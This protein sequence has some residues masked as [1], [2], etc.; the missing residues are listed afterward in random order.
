MSNNLISTSNADFQYP[1]DLNAES[2]LI[3]SCILD[4]SVLADVVKIIGP[5]NFYHT[6]HAIMFGEIAGLHK[7]GKTF[8][9]VILKDR[10][11]SA[12]T[13]DKVGGPENIADILQSVPTS[14][15]AVYYAEIIFE[16]YLL[17]TAINAAAHIMAA[18]SQGKSIDVVRGLYSDAVESLNGHDETENQRKLKTIIERDF[19]RYVIFAAGQDKV[20]EVIDAIIKL[21][22]TPGH[23]SDIV[24]QCLWKMILLKRGKGENIALPYLVDYKKHDLGLGFIGVTG[25]L[26]FVGVEA[27]ADFSQAMIIDY[28]VKI[29]GAFEH[30]KKLTERK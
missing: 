5:E 10:L 28:A 8:D 27:P 9:V 19:I 18:A 15:N 22:L 7:E 11:L 13:L 24:C 21:N 16:K 2:A 1:Y 30:L 23:F 25:L 20:N 3:G 29:L 17:R 12:G 6:P 4:N 26:E 14:S